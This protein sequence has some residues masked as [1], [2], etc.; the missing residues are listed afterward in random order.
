MLT[1]VKYVMYTYKHACYV[2][3][4]K[5]SVVIFWGFFSSLILALDG[6]EIEVHFV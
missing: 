5:R 6:I 3:S 4:L 2:I 1:C